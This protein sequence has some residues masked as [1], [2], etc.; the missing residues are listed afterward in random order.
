MNL[1]ETYNWIYKICL[2]KARRDDFGLIEA[3]ESDYIEDAVQ[4]IMTR[5]L[6]HGNLNTDSELKLFILRQSDNIFSK[7][8]ERNY[9]VTLYQD[10]YDEIIQSLL[11]GDNPDFE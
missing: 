5:V 6:E 9:K 10:G 7:F 11:Y 4:E 8:R 3:R 2:G 1:E